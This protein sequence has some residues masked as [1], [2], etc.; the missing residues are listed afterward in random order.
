MEG[1]IRV[2]S[3]PGKGSRFLFT[4]KFQTGNK[5][6]NILQ[7]PEDLTGLRVLVVDDNPSARE[8][9]THILQSFSFQATQVSSGEEAL[10]EL[11]DA[12]SEKRYDLVLLDWKMP[13]MNGIDTAKRIKTLVNGKIPAILMISAF[14]REEIVKK[15]ESIGID[16]F[17][18]KP[19]NESL[20]FDTIME[21]FGKPVRDL[22]TSRHSKPDST[23]VL[24]D[25]QNARI[26]LV[27]DN[28]FNQIVRY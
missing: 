17:L 26:L 14:G 2:E 23:I 8:I 12:D 18:T 4:A 19:V 10:K 22:S 5:T 7:F 21:I 11:E 3:E 15:A 13:G 25:I 27:E 1:E 16:A 9:L 24:K 6:R 28:K 20:L